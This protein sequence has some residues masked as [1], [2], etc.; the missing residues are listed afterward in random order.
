[1]L[2]SLLVKAYSVQHNLDVKDF[3]DDYMMLLNDILEGLWRAIEWRKKSGRMIPF[4]RKDGIFRKE[5]RDTYIKEWIYSKHYV[6]SAIK[7][8]YSILNS[9]RKKYLKGRACREK[10]TLK[11][12]FV[13]VKET[14]Y[15]YRGG[16]IRISIKPFQESIYI[17]LKKAWFWDRI[18]GLDLGELW[19]SSRE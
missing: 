14:L 6:D 19:A 8:V 18:A 7:Q 1:V 12:G 2:E 9:W 5:L 17:D 10:P 4:I 13:R 15:S 16:I 3:I 11:R